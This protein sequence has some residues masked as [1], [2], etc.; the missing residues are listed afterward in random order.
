VSNATS[1]PATPNVRLSSRTPLRCLTKSPHPNDRGPALS[2]SSQGRSTGPKIPTTSSPPSK[3][4][5]RCSILSAGAALSIAFRGKAGHA[6][7]MAAAQPVQV[8]TTAF[9]RRAPPSVGSKSPKDV[10]PGVG[11]RHLSRFRISRFRTPT[12]ICKPNRWRI[13]LVPPMRSTHPLL[14]TETKTNVSV[15]RAEDT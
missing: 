8:T 1:P 6:A 12:S 10:R 9:G 13:D 11:I 14:E 4:G 3:K 15:S 7:E 5:A 2:S